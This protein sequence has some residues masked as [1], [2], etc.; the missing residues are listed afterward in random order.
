[1]VKAGFFPYHLVRANYGKLRQIT[2]NNAELQLKD[3]SVNRITI[4]FGLTDS[5]LFYHEKL[6]EFGTSHLLRMKS[7]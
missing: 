6:T 1:M 5:S 2:V 3:G 4:F 7:L